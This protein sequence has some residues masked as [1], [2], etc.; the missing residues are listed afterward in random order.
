MSALGN[1]FVMLQFFISCL[2]A[3]RMF[4]FAYSPHHS[5]GRANSSL[6]AFICAGWF[7]PPPYSLLK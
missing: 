6:S 1:V 5:T 2:R 7:F 4:L 3:T